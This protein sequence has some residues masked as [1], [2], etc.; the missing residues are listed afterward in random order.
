MNI[1]YFDKQNLLF[2]TEAANMLADAFPQSYKDTAGEEMTAILDDERLTL[3]A[4]EDG[5]LLGFIGA[6]PSYGITGWELHP[7]VVAN[8]Q[9]GRGIGSL[10]VS[11]LEEEVTAKGGLMIFLGTDDEHFQTSLSSG[12]LFE[13]TFDKIKNIQNLNKHPYE[14]YQ[15]VGYAIVGVLPDA[16][17][18]GKPDI[19]MAKRLKNPEN[20]KP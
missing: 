10:L 13:H 3:M 15:K 19:F 17:G 2:V 16:N 9:R 1:S 4:V 6:I 12:D 5:K 11:R 8:S 14:F 20:I 18:F 7:I